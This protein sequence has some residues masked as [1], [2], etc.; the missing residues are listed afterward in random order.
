MAMLPERIETDRLKLRP[1]RLEDVDDIL[2]FAS[3]PEWARY[4]PVP[5]PYTKSD[6]EK[7]VAG[8]LSRDRKTD[9]SWAIEHAGSVIGGINIKFDFDNRVGRIGYSIAR[10]FWGKGLTTEAA[11]AVIDEAFS[12]YPDLNRVHSWA[13]ERNAGSLRVMEKLGMRREGVLRQSIYER[14]EF[15]NAVWCGILRDEWEAYKPE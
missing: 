14:G 5:Q 15:I 6:A 13:D 10:G 2:S 7:F 12:A 8:Q 3:D 11:R 9:P 4:L 1:F